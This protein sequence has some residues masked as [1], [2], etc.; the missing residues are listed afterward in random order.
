[1]EI[2]S[3]R[4]SRRQA[5]GVFGAAAAVTALGTS[6]GVA[7]A[8]TSAGGNAPRVLVD[9]V[10]AEV[11]TYAYPSEVGELVL[12]NGLIRFTFGASNAS[13]S[14]VVVDGTELAHNLTG[15]SF[16][17]DAWGGKAGLVCSQVQ[18]LRLT[19]DLVEVALVDTTSSPLGHEH[20]LIMRS[21]RRGLYGYDVMTAREATEIN[22]VR[23]NSRWD[24]AIFDHAFSWE[25][26]SGR[27]P[28]YAYLNTQER[29]Q[30]E[31]WRVDGIN[32][33]DL[34]APDSN[35]GNL[36]RGTV[37][38]K[39]NWSLYHHENPM[40]GHYGHGF[41]VWFT[42]LGGVTEDTLC[43]YYGVGPNHQDLAI[44]QDAI[45]LNYFGANHYGLP[46][47]ALPA[48][49][50]RL[51]GPWLTYVTT[52]DPDD[53]SAMIADARRI[54]DEEIAADRRGASWVDDPLYP[55]PGER[56]TVTGRLRIADGRAAGEVWV[57]LTTQDV[58]DLYTVHE[59]TYFVKTQPDGSFRI[60]GVPPAWKPGTTNA[61]TYTLYAFAGRG[62]VTDQY[63]RTG[64]TVSG[65][66]QDLGELMWT[67]T[68]RTTFLWQIGGAGR[69]GAEFA[70]ATDPA[71]W[72]HPRSYEKPSK[73]PGDLTF[74]IGRS[75]EPEDW[76]YA[77]TQE[78][79]WTIR[80]DLD[81]AYTG[82]AYLTMSSSMQQGSPPTVAVNG[83]TDDITGTLPDNKDSTIPRQAD[84]SG[85]PRLAVLSFPA[86]MLRTGANTV[87]LTR[88][89]GT[90]A[91]DGLGWDT[92]LLEVDEPAA[93][94]AARLTASLRVSRP[95]GP[96]GMTTWTVEV[97]NTGAGD[98]HDVRLDAFVP[99]G[100]ADWPGSKRPVVEGRDPAR[101]PVPVAARI[102]P[103]GKA[104]AQLR[105]DFSEAPRLYRA[106]ME[107]SVS[108]DG[109]RARTAAEAR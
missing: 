28:T 41:G 75:W 62:S 33:P 56:T 40:F 45:V 6:S 102:A 100:G 32:N 88:G 96:P 14:S 2:G 19:P 59:P 34:P 10:P 23:M 87:T 48:G 5:L 66:V 60:P 67:P 97:T 101:F 85:H 81:R 1:M 54:A 39:Y 61:G 99:A 86:A 82:T 109:G 13:V 73:V 55:G 103:G 3:G 8:A 18:V 25:R 46:A 83:S 24:R 78:G 105:V 70:L 107:I 106:R 11:R 29:V 44:H 65:R 79:T 42:P 51:Y 72:S 17:V 7:S 9:G 43:A 98:A 53:P 21:G 93:P 37:Y 16:Y 30:D 64:I 36:P 108:A 77:Q 12:D 47:Y 80:F 95:A 76:Y 84:R 104:T 20:H 57:V 22:E 27:Q 92:L 52:G 26:G 38:S 90:P 50:R 35:S 58:D 94:P 68:D 91:G 4:V 63:K 71:S 49:Y 31:T 74:T 89:A 15:R 69:T